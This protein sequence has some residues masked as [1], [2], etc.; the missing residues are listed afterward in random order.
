V[1][2]A[3]SAWLRRL[4]GAQPGWRR[5]VCFPHAG[6]GASFFRSWHARVPP[7]VELLAVQYP[8]RE[9][10]VG[11]P[12][13]DD[14]GTL[15]DAI[16]GAL[17]GVLDGPLVLFGHSMGAAVAHEV[18]GRISGRA[19]RR[20]RGLVVSARPGPRHAVPGTRHLEPDD[21]L[22][23]ELRR[24]NGT[25]EALVGHHELRRLLLPCLRRDYRLIETYRH[26]PGPLLDCPVV[27]CL[28]DADPELTPEQAACWREA[29]RGPFDV[30][31]F[32]G[33]DHFYLRRH[34]DELLALAVGMLG[35]PAWE[36][37]PFP[38]TP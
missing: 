31:V 28:G 20:L 7:S 32:A 11:E 33:G 30:R 14:M 27:A 2:G 35:V 19:G 16:A 8:G 23:G 3:P 1:T 15:A 37:A 26:R 12:A 6:G 17:V 24:L 13:I 5:I 25:H 18:A 36:A 9:D 34:R 29:T 10:R 22:W 21:A 4:P 38:S